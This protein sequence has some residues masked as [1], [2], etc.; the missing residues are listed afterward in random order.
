MVIDG[1]MWFLNLCF[2]LN[3]SV[4]TDRVENFSIIHNTVYHL[5]FTATTKNK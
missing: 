3:I 5:D 1:V 4:S 2:V